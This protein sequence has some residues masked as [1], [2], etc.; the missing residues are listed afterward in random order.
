[1]LKRNKKII[2]LMVFTTVLFSNLPLNTTIALAKENES[3][4]IQENIN[5]YEAMDRLGDL[6]KTN[7]LLANENIKEVTQTN[8][9]SLTKVEI[10]IENDKLSG[11]NVSAQD[12]KDLILNTLRTNLTNLS[13]IEFK[14]D[15]DEFTME[16]F[17]INTTNIKLEDYINNTLESVSHQISIPR[18]AITSTLTDIDFNEISNE[19]PDTLNKNTVIGKAFDESNSYYNLNNLIPSTTNIASYLNIGAYPLL[20]LS[21]LNSINE[22]LLGIKIYNSTTNKLYSVDDID[23][24]QKLLLKDINLTENLNIKIVYI[25]K[26]ESNIVKY[27]TQNQSYKKSTKGETNFKIPTLSNTIDNGLE[28]YTGLINL[29]SELKLQEKKDNLL[30]VI[31]YAISDNY[32]KSPLLFATDY[33]SFTFDNDINNKVKSLEIFLLDSNGEVYTE[34]LNEIINLTRK[35]FSSNN[36]PLEL[37]FNNT[38][39][40]TSFKITKIN[41]MKL[42]NDIIINKNKATL[43]WINSEYIIK[44]GNNTV[45]L[46]NGSQNYTLSF[47]ANVSKFNLIEN[48]SNNLSINSDR[49]IILDKDTSS[50]YIDILANKALDLD[51]SD[52][53]TFQGN[54]NLNYSYEKLT[55]YSF[56]IKVSNIPT[57]KDHL[58]NLKVFFK[59]KEG[60]SHNLTY[61]IIKD[62]TAPTIA[63]EESEKYK[64]IENMLYFKG[65]P[66]SENEVS[67]K[68]S[69][70]SGPVYVS[71]IEKAIDENNSEKLPE[72][73]RHS[74]YYSYDEDSKIL[75]IKNLEYDKPATF[76]ITLKDKYDHEIKYKYSF[77]SDTKAPELSILNSINNSYEINNKS[78]FVQNHKIVDE[79]VNINFSVKDNDREDNLTIDKSSVN[80]YL[81]GA[82]QNEISYDEENKIYTVTVKKDALNS[83]GANISYTAKDIVNNKSIDN[84]YKL[85]YIS[86]EIDSNKVNFNISSTLENNTYAEATVKNSN[87]KYELNI[88]NKLKDDKLKID[89]SKDFI[90]IKNDII[91]DK[92]KIKYNNEE[93]IIDYDDNKYA[94][95]EFKLQRGINIIEYTIETYN[96]IP[97]KGKIIFNYDYTLPTLEIIDANNSSLNLNSSPYISSPIKTLKIFDNGFKEVNNASL[98]FKNNSTGEEIALSLNDFK[99]ENEYLIYNLPDSLTFK[100]GN[101]TFNYS[102][103]SSLDINSESN[104]FNTGIKSYTSNDIKFIYDETKPEIIMKNFNLDFASC[105]IYSTPQDIIIGNLGSGSDIEAEDNLNNEL[106][107]YYQVIDLKTNEVVF[108]DNTKNSISISTLVDGKYKLVLKA[109]DIIGNE[110]ASYEGYFIIDSTSPN[111]SL[112]GLS[113]IDNKYYTYSVNP[114][115]TIEDYSIIDGNISV[116]LNGKTIKTFAINQSHINNYSNVFDL[117][118]LSE[119]GRYNIYIEVKDRNN[120]SSTFVRNFSI[121]KT[122]PI[123]NNVTIGEKTASSNNINYITNHNS[124]IIASYSD[125]LEKV[126]DIKLSLI[127]KKDGISRTLSN[128]EALT[129]DGDYTITVQATDMAGNTS[130]LYSY[131]IIVDTI[132]PEI[133]INDVN[134]G[135]YY[136]KDIKPTWNVND[137]NAQVSVT[138]N[139]NPYDGSVITNE[140]NYT[141]KIVAVDEASNTSIKT[142]NFVIDKTAPNITVEGIKNLGYYTS[143]V[144]PI[145]KWD[146]PDAIATVLLNNI[147]FFGEEI[148]EDGSYVLFAKAVD[149]AGNVSNLSIKFRLNVSK[150]VITVLGFKNG[151]VLSGPITPSFKFKDT[152]E[153]TILLNGKEYHGEELSKDGFYEFVVTAKDEDGVETTETF[154]LTIQNTSAEVSSK[155]NANSKSNNNSTK[156]IKNRANVALAIGSVSGLLALAAI[157]YIIYRKTKRREE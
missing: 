3:A 108:N 70:F 154:S 66:S 107:F 1:M 10:K 91:L 81:N 57:D 87:N 56:R 33:S 137:S 46:S 37:K 152:V 62:I 114:R 29:N 124:P 97:Y 58:S 113:N 17:I 80:F 22:E 42:T 44:N 88:T 16:I 51:S 36:N 49:E 64:D 82:I 130:D 83:E 48:L 77:Y 45:T 142:L 6:F 73:R 145:V 157:G 50:F 40:L 61:K 102:I 138:L 19:L 112:Q 71:S 53:V 92:I 148:N 141:I 79:K 7:N 78:I 117:G 69:D 118:E 104:N 25:A 67:F 54:N 75:K 93:D 86:E 133:S 143:S 65:Y 68:V 115:V 30:P 94:V 12:C 131:R 90:D 146:D 74:E 47:T 5:Q 32:K 150:P 72:Y 126:D 21:Y 100:E 28:K 85:Y 27:H 20:D 132:L 156:E 99:R 8:F 76:K 89:F 39:N 147:N 128:G 106:T 96:S 23:T 136:N 59:D 123:I 55:D 26:D 60:T 127:A 129:E 34:S 11:K 15:K 2:S 120:N 110:S 116:V 153:Y 140:G 38:S 101:Y 151:D 98:L 14:I 95:K 41:D 84:S 4:L 155:N 111:I 119:D 134:D 125:N 31:G 43:D 139:S 13:E 109:K 149:K 24:T 52:A 135:H 121:D 9:N 18:N 35:N 144:T 105:K 63:L 122:A 103:N